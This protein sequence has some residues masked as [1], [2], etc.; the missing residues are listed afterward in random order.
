MVLHRTC[1]G[2]GRRDFL[3]AGAAGAAGLTL[4]SYLQMA[5]A[6]ALRS[7]AK[8]KAAIFVNLNGG[9]SHLDMFDLKPEASDEYRGEF[10]AIQTNL[11]GVQ[12]SEHL[13]KMATCMDKYTLLRGVTHSVAAHQLGTEYVNT[14][15]RPLPSL[16]FPG[17]GAVIS[18]E[19]AGSPELPQFV[20]IPNSAQRPG[21][22][23][24]RYAPMNTTAT[25]QIGTPFKVRGMSLGGGLT[26][27]DVE[28]RRN[29]L[30]KLDN[31]FGEFEKQNQLLEGLDSFGQQA[32]TMITSK[33][34]REA[35]D[36][37]KETPEFSERFGTSGF[38][39]SCLLAIRLV[40]AG[41]NFVTVSNGGWDTHNDN[42]NTLKTRQLPAFD[43]AISGL[44][45]GLADRGLLESTIVF[46]T[47]EFG[48]TPK[49][50]KERNGRDHYP[51]NMFMLLAG[52]G[53]RGGQVLGESD[54]TGSMPKHEGYSPDDVAATFYSALGIDHTKEYHTSTGRPVMIVRD[55]KPIPE[56]F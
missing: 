43:A 39:A 35:F 52:G 24:V 22:L 55:G 30:T 6:G 1:D 21:Y 23:G 17:Y 36:I 25:P 38:G 11:P 27:D 32:H 54:E 47:G 8:A 33:K 14:G 12:I 56:V 7:G 10:A 31:T 18:K 2:V 9:P 13:P 44:F 19:L 48:R 40:E 29:L 5:Q 16:E 41:V 4:A 53:V 28:K 15:N 46:V 42:W 50:N 3:R 26:I 20:A 37:S 34:A 45:T 49:I 51:R